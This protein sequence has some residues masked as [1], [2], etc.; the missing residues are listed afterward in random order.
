MLTLIGQRGLDI[1][2]SGGEAASS[3]IPCCE[4]S[5]LD[6]AAAYWPFRTEVPAIHVKFSAFCPSRLAPGRDF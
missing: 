5:S 2:T 4:N 1:P 6:F 3:P